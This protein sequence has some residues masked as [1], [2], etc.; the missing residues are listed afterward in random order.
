MSNTNDTNFMETINRLQNQYYSNNKKNTIFKSGQKEE[1]ASTITNKIGIEDLIKK[2]CFILD[3]TYSVFFDYTIFK[4]Y[5]TSENYEKI[6]E[7]ILS[8]FN[9]C[10]EKYGTFEAHINLNSFTLSA[11]E[12]YKSIINVFINKCMIANSGYS[13][14]INKMYIY[15]TPNTFNN[16]SK[17]LLPLI[18]SEVKQ[19]I[20]LYDKI[21]SFE[22]L[23]NL[24]HK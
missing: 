8:L 19:K 5:A 9:A 16:I 14:K 21:N 10:I 13:I 11:A 4:M 17:I 3:G 18:D 24:L 15:N 6:V 20:V 1:C 22:L 23:N 12:R 2:T 7:Y